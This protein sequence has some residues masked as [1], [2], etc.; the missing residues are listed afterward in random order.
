M[1]YQRLTAYWIGTRTDK[2]HYDYKCSECGKV[3]HYRKELFCPQCGRQ[4]IEKGVKN[5]RN[6]D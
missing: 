6:N 2:H 4:M 3:S 1:D 5:G